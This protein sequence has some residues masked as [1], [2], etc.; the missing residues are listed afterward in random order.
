MIRAVSL[1]N[2]ELIL[3]EW[4]CPLHLLPLVRAKHSVVLRAHISHDVL[5]PPLVGTVAFVPFVG[6]R[7]ERGNLC[8]HDASYQQFQVG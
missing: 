5:E 7:R 8:S 4:H 3:G 2:G 6:A 1:I